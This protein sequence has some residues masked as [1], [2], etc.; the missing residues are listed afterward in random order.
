MD[1]IPSKR[2]EAHALCNVDTWSQLSVPGCPSQVEVE[3]EDEG[4]HDTYLESASLQSD[5]HTQ[6]LS[7]SYL[8]LSNSATHDYDDLRAELP[9]RPKATELSP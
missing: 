8:P 9:P 2:P 7:Q 5:L 3:V 6:L 4:K 1:P